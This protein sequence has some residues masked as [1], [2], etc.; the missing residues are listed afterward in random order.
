MSLAALEARLSAYKRLWRRAFVKGPLTRFVF[1]FIA[2]GIKQGWACLF[3][4]LMLLLL[5][6]SFLVYPADAPLARYDFITVCALAIQIAMLGLKLETWEEAGVILAF[7]LVGTV[8]ELYKTHMGS[9]I[10]PE[11]SVL[12]I[13]DVP[14]FSGFMY[15]CVG[16]YI[17]RVWRLFH[18]E[19]DRFPPL[20]AQGLLA[21]GVYINFFTH[22]FMLDVRW[23]LF[24]V[25]ALLY[26]PCVIWFRPDQ[27]R[28][29]MPL[30]IGLFLVALFIW[31]A[32]NIATYANAWRYPGQ[33]QTWHWVSL[34][35]LGA[36]YLL[37]IISFVLVA[38]IHDTR[39]RLS[40]KTRHNDKRRQP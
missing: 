21:L 4:A 20:W 36:W 7:H 37:M 19:F 23:G 13:G 32:E 31:F 6:G 17:A 24:F 16:S 28:R 1:E 14:L 39:L 26:L 22:H 18:F 5:L 40:L 30:G 12:R 10:Y 15:A 27:A 2:F 3:G 33:D 9:W 34:N 38:A 35:K 29:C 8:M 25:S 11:A